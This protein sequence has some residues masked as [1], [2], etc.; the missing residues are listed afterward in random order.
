MCFSEVRWL[1]LSYSILEVN[2]V[3]LT[4]FTVSDSFSDYLEE[5][6]Y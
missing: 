6:N 2:V 3:L 1:F 4:T 5:S